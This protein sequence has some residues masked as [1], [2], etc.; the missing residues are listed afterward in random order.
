MPENDTLTDERAFRA[1]VTRTLGALLRQL[2][3]LDTDEM[4]AR[5]S[6]GNLTVGFEQGGTFMLSQQT[7]T[8]ELW[9]SANL[10]AWHFRWFRGSWVER[11]SHAPMGEVLERLFGEKL[12]IPVRLKI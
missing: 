10:K 8:R 6:E 12:G 4:D 5:M 11:D 1:E 9:L 3:E 2:D 7:P